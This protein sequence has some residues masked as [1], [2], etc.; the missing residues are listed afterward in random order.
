MK[1]QGKVVLYV[2]DS[3]VLSSLQFALT[4][5]GFVTVDGAAAEDTDFAAAAALVIDQGYLGD[6]LAMLV[7]LRSKGY[8][9]PAL[10]LATNPTT[11]LRVCATAA[12][13]A[14]IEKPLFGN[15]L[16]GAINVAIETREAA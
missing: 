14:L 13:A 6:G 9:G 10:L 3:P 11:R 1:T 8:A 7:A 5:E 15:E 2:G 4:V 12:G 16:S